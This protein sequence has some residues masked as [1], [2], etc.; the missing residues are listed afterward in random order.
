MNS[1]DSVRALSALAHE[2]RLAVFRL[3]VSRGPEGYSAGDLSEQ[4]GIPGPTLSFH[5]KE[6]TQAGLLTSRKASRFIYYSPAFDRMNE[7]LNYLT[8]NCCTQGNLCATACAP[9]HSTKRRR[10]AA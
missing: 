1:Q 9:N 4:L 7:L 10:R 2:S 5:L 6:L 8:E 3:L